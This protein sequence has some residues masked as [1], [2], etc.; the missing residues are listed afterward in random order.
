M[1]ATQ[2][3]GGDE[4][5]SD[6]CAADLPQVTYRA[7]VQPIIHRY[8]VECHDAAKV[9]TAERQ[10]AVFDH[11]YNTYALIT[12]S[13]VFPANT[14]NTA[15]AYS[16]CLRGV[17]SCTLEREVNLAPKMLEAVQPNA[18]PVMPPA[19]YER[20]IDECSRRTLARWV[21]EGTPE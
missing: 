18:N 13:P 11:N 5:D 16:D 21:A 12:R 19:V 17:T 10:S 7:H 3:C 8:C 9:T 2:G 4:N 6:V 15:E 20:P 14:V 1:V